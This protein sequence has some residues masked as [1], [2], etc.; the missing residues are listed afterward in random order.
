VSFQFPKS[1]GKHKDEVE[2]FLKEKYPE[3][4]L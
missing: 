1:L 3:E 4:F 2:E